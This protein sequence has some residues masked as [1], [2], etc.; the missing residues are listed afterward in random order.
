M[1]DVDSDDDDDDSSDEERELDMET[2]DT[3]TLVKDDE[4]RKYL[5]SLPELEREAIL[6]DRFEKLKA[7]QDMKKA[8]RES[9]YVFTLYCSKFDVFKKISGD[10]SFFFSYL[11]FF[12]VPQAQRAR[13]QGTY[14]RHPHLQK[15][16]SR[17]NK[18]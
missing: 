12:I 2:F 14:K 9:K 17:K 18:G 16:S 4:D 6:G 1:G 3:Q 15:K 8:L 10:F 5:D 13:R 11:L 7:E